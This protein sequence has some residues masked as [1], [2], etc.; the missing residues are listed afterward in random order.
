M[1]RFTISQFDSDTFIVV[2]TLQSREFCICGNYE[3]GMDAK[4]RA[5][6]IT[7]VLNTRSSRRLRLPHRI[8]LPR[9]VRR[10]RN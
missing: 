5:R 2:D 8:Y 3:G 7:G 1:Q 6:Y 9:R 10:R 4:N